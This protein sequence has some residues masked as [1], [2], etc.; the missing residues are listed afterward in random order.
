MIATV[1]AMKGDLR[2][3]DKVRKALTSLKI[4]SPRG[5]FAIDPRT[6]NVVQNIY[7]GEVIKKPDGALAHKILKTYENV[8]DPGTGCTL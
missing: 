8:R 3:K 1:E 7:I 4:D 2:D 6:G 5:N